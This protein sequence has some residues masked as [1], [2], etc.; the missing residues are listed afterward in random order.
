MLSNKKI[1]IFSTVFVL[2]IFSTVFAYS[3]ESFKEKYGITTANV[4]LRKQA[5]LNSNSKVLT[6]PK[7]TPLRLLGT[8]DDFYIAQLENN[9]IGLVSKKY[10]N[11]EG[12]SVSNAKPYESLEK[13]FAT[14][15]EN[16]TNIRSGPSTSFDSY[17]KLSADQKVEVIGKIDDFNLVITDNNI[18]GMIRQD[19]ITSLNNDIEI[20]VENTTFV[21][22]LIND[23]RSNNG[24]NKLKTDVLLQATAQ[25]KADDMVKNDYFAH[26][27]PTYGSPF[28]MMQNAGIIYKTAGENIAG[29]PN[30]KDGV[31][32]WLLSD[33]HKQ[34]ILSNAYNYVGIGVEKSDKYGYIIVAMFIGK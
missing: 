7:N 5:N 29:N 33:T 13:Y 21:L 24:L 27:S 10:V 4:N 25:N 11:I 20:P 16:L 26:I 1:L 23:A 31:T 15:N 19:L 18:V 34:N 2:I 14:I 9:K 22:D 17:A 6:I 3:S 32:S 28:K 12:E 30:I 8:I